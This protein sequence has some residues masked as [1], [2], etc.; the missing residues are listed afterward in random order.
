MAWHTKFHYAAVLLALT[1][2]LEK[3]KC[4][5]SCANGSSY[6]ADCLHTYL[7]RDFPS[8]EAIVFP[9]KRGN[10]KAKVL[11]LDGPELEDQCHRIGEVVECLEDLQPDCYYYNEFFPFRHLVA[12]LRKSINWVCTPEHLRSRFR[13]LLNAF[14]CLETARQQ[15]SSQGQPCFHP[16]IPANIWQRIVRLQSGTEVCKAL[17]GHMNCT[18]S[19]TTSCPVEAQVVYKELN[20][21]FLNAWCTPSQIFAS[22]A[23]ST[24][25][26]STLSLIIALALISVLGYFV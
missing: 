21:L 1:V 3:T 18:Q 7:E 11:L 19:Y 2:F 17:T 9:K 26:S 10:Q 14:S 20:Q 13:T 15:A 8:I 23:E 12:S 5:P 4:E 22:R 25:P 6:V 16:N 24:F